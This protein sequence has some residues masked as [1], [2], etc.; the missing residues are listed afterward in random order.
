MNSKF[1]LCCRLCCFLCFRFMKREH[2][3][4]VTEVFRVLSVEKKLR[5]VKLGFYLLLFVLVMTRIYAAGT[6]SVVM[7]VFHSDNEELDIRSSI[8]EF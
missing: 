3:I 1:F 8:L 5:V 7:S 2:L 6:F 4:D